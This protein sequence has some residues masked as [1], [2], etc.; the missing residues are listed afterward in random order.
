MTFY[1]LYGVGGDSKVLEFIS[2]GFRP[3]RHVDVVL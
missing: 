1:V 2:L 3:L